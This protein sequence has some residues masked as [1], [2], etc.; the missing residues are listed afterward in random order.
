MYIQPT[1]PF[2]YKM[3]YQWYN[4]ASVKFEMIRYLYNREF[5]LLVPRFIE[6][7]EVKKRSVRNLKSHNVQGFDFNLRATDMFKKET[8]YNF[9]YS[10][11]RYKNGLPDQTLNFAERD[12]TDWNKNCYKSIIS[13]DYLIDIDAPDFNDMQMAYESAYN[14]KELFDKF[15]VPYELRLSSLGFHFV[16]PYKYLPQNLTLNPHEENNLYQFL[17]KLT[18]FIFEECSEMIDTNIY[19]SRR[20][21]K[22]PYSL[23]L[24]YHDAFVCSPFLNNTEFENFKLY[25]YRPNNYPF[26]IERRGTKIFNEQGNL[27]LLLLHFELN[28]YIKGL[29]VNQNSTILSAKKEEIDKVKEEGY[30]A[31]IGLP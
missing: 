19:D 5:S 30:Y 9:Y 10:M 28:K 24:Y 1:K 21:C 11:A 16:I 18:K 29:I 15:K 2:P 17:S 26:N 3:I 8:P 14:V 12:N 22:I 25:N 13:Y 31:G 27:S 6:D 23:A 7:K 4:L 20:L